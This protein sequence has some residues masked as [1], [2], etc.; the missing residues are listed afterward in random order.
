MLFGRSGKRI[1][2]VIR[3]TD[4]LTQW[5]WGVSI[6]RKMIPFTW[7]VTT[8]VLK[9]ALDGL[10]PGR[11]RYLDMGCGHV[12]L[13]GQYVKRTHS[14]AEVISVDFY[15]DFAENA[16]INAKHNNLD[17]EVRQSDLFSAVPEKFD[18]ITT[19]L[20]YKPESKK[21]SGAKST[22]MWD[23]TTFSGDEG[24]DTSRKFLAEAHSH[25]EPGGRIL[26][27]VN[28]Y[29]L[30]ESRCLELI[31]QAGY[32]VETIVGRRFNTARVFVLSS[33]RA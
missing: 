21:S 4:R 11:L 30:S 7:D 3:S 27:G 33:H 22:V 24:A 26:F 15:P 8:L 12:C 9:T 16:R 32:A 23:K 6:H 29:F 1:L 28:C 17:I 20:P 10:A 13:L 19:N 31:E 14:G 18:L 25:L 2:D 5:A